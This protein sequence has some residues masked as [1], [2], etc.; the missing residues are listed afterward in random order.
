LTPLRFGETE[1]IPDRYSV[2]KERIPLGA[3]HRLYARHPCEDT[4]PNAWWR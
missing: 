4:T 3:E 1:W 2:V